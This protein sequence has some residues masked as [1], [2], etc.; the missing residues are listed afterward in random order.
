MNSTLKLKDLK[1]YL[2]RQTREVKARAQQLGFNQAGQGTAEYVLLLVIIVAL[3]FGIIYQFNGSFARYMQSY[4]GEYLACLLETGELPAGLSSG[5]G[6]CRSEL[7]AF[8][9]AS[10]Q[11]RAY[12]QRGGAGGLSPAGG[13]TR[14]APAKEGRSESPN[15]AAR[16]GG[17][18]Q[19]GSES[20][21]VASSSRSSGSPS[22]PSFLSRLGRNRAQRSI[23]S[24]SEGS[25]DDLGSLGRSNLQSS[26]SPFARSA[27]R[28]MPDDKIFA[29]RIDNPSD[30]LRP[31]KVEKVASVPSESLR[32]KKIRIKIVNL[33]TASISETDDTWSFSGIF[34]FIIIAAIVIALFVVVGGQVFQVSKQMD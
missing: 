7:E 21:P 33:T 17:R 16:E 23:S 32:Q 26:G 14:G 27:S 2:N 8:D 34:R 19:P 25:S 30:A 12:G 31:S 18:T 6:Q 5:L 11:S 13:A 28:F 24:S 3:C 29:F 20:F 1:Q 22:S 4:Y 9:L 10:G 15:A